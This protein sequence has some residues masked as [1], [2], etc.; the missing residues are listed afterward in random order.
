MEKKATEAPIVNEANAFIPNIRGTIAMARTSEPNS[1]TSQF[2]INLVNNK[3]LNKTSLNPGYAVF[4][5]VIQGMDVVDQIA[6][7]KT[8]NKGMM[9]NV[10][11][12][13]IEIIKVT[14]EPKP[15]EQDSG[16][17]TISTNG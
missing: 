12:E 3:N 17:S 14:I 8:S 10:P 16:K 1:A 5:R 9:R 7:T 6:R 4:G 2:F 11:I 13:P 15:S